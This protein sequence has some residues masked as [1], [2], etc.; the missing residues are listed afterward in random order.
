M[1]EGQFRGCPTTAKPAPADWALKPM[2]VGAAPQ[3][4][5]ARTSSR[6][7]PRGRFPTFRFMILGVA[8]MVGTG[9]TTLTRALAARFGLQTALESVDADNPWLESFYGSSE[10]MRTYALHL[11][12]H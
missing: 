6:L 9:K 4:P 1:G 11:Q 2:M 8:G 3:W 7:S 5:T 12:L 10:D